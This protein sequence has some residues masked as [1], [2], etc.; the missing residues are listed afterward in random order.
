MN[1]DR[2][3]NSRESLVLVPEAIRCHERESGV[4]GGRAFIVARP[5]RELFREPEIW[6][7]ARS[8]IFA[9]EG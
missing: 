9:L 8:R 1:E 7:A 5:Q 2:P 6:V 3:G 4:T